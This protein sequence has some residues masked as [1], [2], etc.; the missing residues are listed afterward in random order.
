MTPY[1]DIA[2][3]SFDLCWQEARGRKYRQWITS[4]SIEM[5]ITF[6]LRELQLFALIIQT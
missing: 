4:K 1:G 3:I 5:D 2:L 6:R